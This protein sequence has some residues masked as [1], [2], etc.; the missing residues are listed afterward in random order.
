MTDHLIGWLGGF[1]DTNQPSDWVINE[2]WLWHN[3]GRF[4]NIIWQIDW[5]INWHWLTVPSDCWSTGNDLCSDWYV[6]WHLL[7][8]WSVGQLTLTYYL[9]GWSTDICWQ[10]DWLVN[11][12]WLTNYLW[13]VSLPDSAP[14]SA[15]GSSDDHHGCRQIPFLSSKRLYWYHLAIYKIK[16]YS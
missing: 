13:L 12:H 14:Q 11:W 8:I 2:H 1:I 3:F 10:S 7:T 9:I 6:K 15:A 4:T 16:Q 5:S